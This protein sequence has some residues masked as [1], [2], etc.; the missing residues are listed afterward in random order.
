MAVTYQPASRYSALQWCETGAFL[1]LA[2]ALGGLCYL[3]IR[4]PS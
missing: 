4:R 1:V 3:R 2:L